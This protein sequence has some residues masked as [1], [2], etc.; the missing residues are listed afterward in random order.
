MSAPTGRTQLVGGHMLGDETT[1]IGYSVFSAS[2]KPPQKAS[3]PRMI[4][5]ISSRLLTV[6]W[7]RRNSPKLSKIVAQ[8]A[9]PDPRHFSPESNLSIVRPAFN[10]ET[11]HHSKSLVRVWT[12]PRF[13]SNTPRLRQVDCRP[14]SLTCSQSP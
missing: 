4:T 13:L 2:L 6:S 3:A 8:S 11:P 12:V 7:T 1:S 14:M 5:A 9:M 10:Q